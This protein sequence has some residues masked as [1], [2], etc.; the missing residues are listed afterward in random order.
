MM[1]V[2]FSRALHAC[3]SSAG[4]SQK[5]ISNFQRASKHLSR[6]NSSEGPEI[7]VQVDMV[8]GVP[9]LCLMKPDVCLESSDV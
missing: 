8:E 4:E 1:H 6:A 9:S 2:S 3:S 5:Q 7:V